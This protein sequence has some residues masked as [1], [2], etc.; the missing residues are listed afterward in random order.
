LSSSFS[1]SSPAYSPSSLPLVHLIILLFLSSFSSLLFFQII[2]KAE[3]TA[4]TFHTSVKFEDV[5]NLVVRTRATMIENVLASI[6]LD[7]DITNKASRLQ[8]TFSDLA[9]SKVPFDA[10][11]PAVFQAAQAMS[12][13]K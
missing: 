8:K 1:S 7:E 10:I 2:K 4:A 13:T 5:E 6:M 9:L 12:K 3:K 11:H